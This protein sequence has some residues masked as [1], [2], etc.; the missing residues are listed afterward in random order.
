M[1]AAVIDPVEATIT[2]QEHPDPVAGPGQLLVRVRAAGLN[3]ADLLA[4][5][6]RY[7][8]G[9]TKTPPKPMV[10]GAEFAG[11]VVAVGDG[12]GGWQVG[13]RVMS[14]GAGYA[15]LALADARLAMPVPQILSW[16]QA[17]ALPVALLTMHD[18][19]V[20]NGRWSTGE[21]VAITA[22]TSGVGVVGVQI[23]L[24]LGAPLVLG[25]SRS[26]HKR[27]AL[28]R[29]VSNERF[30]MC[31]PDDYVEAARGLTASRGIDV[32]IDNVGASA[33][34]ACVD[35]AAIQGRIVQVGRLGGR[36]GTFDLDELA[37]KTHFR[38]SA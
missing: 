25:T 29:I 13:D 8:V 7:V 36:H 32:T 35:G 3:R 28:A 37:R 10:A 4:R 9:T 15:E 6:G 1:R 16:E 27:P 17:G 19:I 11:E 30:T 38:L 31:G 20:T 14:Q 33:I 12:V 34:A 21:S 23:A 24:H 22:A 5:A 2:V 18:A 26:K